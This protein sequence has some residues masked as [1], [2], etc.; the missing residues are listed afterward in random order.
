MPKK[1]GMTVIKNWQDEMVSTKVQNNWR[2]C[3]NYR[4]LNQTTRKDHF[5]LS[6]VDQVLYAD[7]H[8]THGSIQDYLHMSVQNVHIYKDVVWT[9]QCP[10]YLLKMHDQHLLGPLRG[11]YARHLVSIRGIEVDKGKIDV[12]SSLPPPPSLPNP[13]SVREDAD[14]VFNQPYVDAFQ[15][16][17]RR[18][19]SAPI[20]QAPNWELPF[21]LVCDAS[22]SMLGAVLSQRAGKQSHVIAYAS[23][24]MDSAQFNYTTTEKELLAIVFALDKFSAEVPLEE[25]RCKAETDLFDFEIRDKKGVENVVV[26]HL[27]RLERE[28]E[29]IPIRDEFPNEQIL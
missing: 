17:K 6:F 25:A 15:E 9:L 10:E 2:V 28:V 24:T 21:E 13:A 5:P 7:S 27:S 18:L 11:L 23:R 20:L 14:F 22:N 29:P 3:I 4:K 19:T 8:S 16:L 1:S 26:D 12:I